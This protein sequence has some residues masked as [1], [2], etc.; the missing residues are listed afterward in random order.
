M[1][2]WLGCWACKMVVP[3]FGSSALL[4]PGRGCLCCVVRQ[5]T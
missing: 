2:E 3:G 5:D 1:A 4:L